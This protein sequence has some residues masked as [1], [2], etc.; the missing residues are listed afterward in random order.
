MGNSII[1]HRDIGQG[2]RV[3]SL[4]P[5]A[6]AAGAFTTNWVDLG[7]SA[8]GKLFVHV[9]A[10]AGTPDSFSVAV[11]LRMCPDNGAGAPDDELA[12]I[13]SDPEAVAATVT[14]TAASTTGELNVRLA[15]SNKK[16]WAQI[17]AIAAFVGGTTPS[18]PIA[19]VFI[20]NDDDYPAAPA[21]AYVA[22]D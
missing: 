2:L 5:A 1:P 4:V 12:A 11:S 19:A 13:Y 10:T 3:A 16:K 9:G 7:R 6:R 8:S 21:V 20:A 17:S 22:G 15:G 14:I 18:I